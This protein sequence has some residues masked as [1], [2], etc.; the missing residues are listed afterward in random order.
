MIDTVTLFSPHEIDTAP[1]DGYIRR[2]TDYSEPEYKLK[3]SFTNQKTGFWASGADSALHYFRASLP[4]LRHG[5]NGWLIKNQPELDEGL[6]L[7]EA[8]ADAL[9]PRKDVANHFT[10]VALCWQ[11]R[12]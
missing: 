4:R 1:H 11:F 9:G 10:K 6:R 8:A 7:F 12:I 2:R 3:Y 5:D